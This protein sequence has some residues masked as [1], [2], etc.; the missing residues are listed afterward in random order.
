MYPYFYPSVNRFAVALQPD[1]ASFVQLS[2][3]RELRITR[4]IDVNNQERFHDQCPQRELVL[5]AR[6]FIQEVSLVFLC[7]QPT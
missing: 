1:C 6:M 2:V 7:H 5:E 4:T 3:N